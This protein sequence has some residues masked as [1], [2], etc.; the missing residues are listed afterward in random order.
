MDGKRPPE[1]PIGD[2]V[3]M[4]ND[5]TSASLA[6]CNRG[7]LDPSANIEPWLFSKEQ[8]LVHLGTRVSQW[9]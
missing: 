4:F 6:Q 3:L 1:G 7:T 9:F 5:G 8:N 2:A